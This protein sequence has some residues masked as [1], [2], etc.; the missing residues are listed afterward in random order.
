M[1]S[2]GRGDRR[3]GLDDDYRTPA[4]C[5]RR[6][7]DTGKTPLSADF[8]EESRPL[9]CDPC[10]G[11]GA[12]PNAV[13]EWR[14]AHGLVLPRWFLIEVRPAMEEALHAVDGVMRVVIDDA[15]GA[16][17]RQAVVN[18]KVRPVVEYQRKAAS[19]DASVKLS[20][21]NPPF[22]LAML[23][24]KRFRY[25]GAAAF[26]LQRGNFCGGEERHDDFADLPDRYDL[27]NRVDFTGD[28]RTDSIG[29]SWYGLPR[30]NGTP[31]W[32]LLGLTP[33]DERRGDRPLVSRDRPMPT[34]EGRLKKRRR[35]QHGDD[36]RSQ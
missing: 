4:W 2:S 12:I 26:M 29:H 30:I 28:G 27:P 16:R 14:R 23:F 32:T 24:W 22:P 20:I 10:A 7:M 31:S 21:F 34:G 15:V 3:G 8:T 25:F 1:T 17:V 9:W 11:D 5:V 13:N 36:P 6:L 18:G 35:R 19:V 33:I